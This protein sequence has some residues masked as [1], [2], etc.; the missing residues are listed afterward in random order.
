MHGFQNQKGHPAGHIPASVGREPADLGVV[1]V[2]K[3]QAG[4]VPDRF[5][6]GED[7]VGYI[8]LVKRAEQFV[9]LAQGSPAEIGAVHTLKMG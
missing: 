8:L 3:K 4:N 5:L 1:S 7:A 6:I 9:Q 2:V